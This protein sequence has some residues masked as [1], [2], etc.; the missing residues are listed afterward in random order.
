LE[1]LAPLELLAPRD[2]LAQQVQQDLKESKGRQG[3]QGRKVFKGRQARRERPAR[4]ELKAF[5]G[6]QEPRAPL[7]LLPSGISRALTVAALH[8]QLGTSRRTVVR[9][10]TALTRTAAT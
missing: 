3:R 1:R 10:G 2:P 7:V 5:K 9:L 8:M 4:R 6:R